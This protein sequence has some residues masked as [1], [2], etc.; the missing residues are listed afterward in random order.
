SRR[1]KTERSRLA[2]GRGYGTARAPRD[3][4]CV[5]VV[6]SVTETF[7]STPFTFNGNGDCRVF[8][9]SA[10]MQ[11]RA[12]V[13]THTSSLV[14]RVG[15]VAPRCRDWG[16]RRIFHFRVEPDARDRRLR[17]MEL[18]VRCS[19]GSCRCGTY[20]PAELTTHMSGST[21]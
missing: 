16:H 6:T 2:T 17:S 9:P 19:L 20:V 8:D 4:R 10:R 21:N 3:G 15:Q 13:T 18:P 12:G 1:R 11:R 7:W 5:P 14:A